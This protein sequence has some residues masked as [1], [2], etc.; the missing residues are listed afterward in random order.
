MVESNY[1]ILLRDEGR[2]IAAVVPP[3]LPD[4][5]YPQGLYIRGLKY[6]P[7]CDEET[8]FF[9]DELHDR[10]GATVGYTF[11]LPDSP[12]FQRSSFIQDSRNVRLDGEEVTIF[13]QTYDS[14]VWECVQ[15]FGSQIYAR[16]DDPR[17]CVL[18][19]FDWSGNRIAFPLH[20]EV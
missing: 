14:P 10:D 20:S 19:M 7:L 16:E 13:L 2:V 18:Y 1:Y 6:L 8:F 5:D 15:G 3:Q 4:E 11:F 17:D 9:W 12:T